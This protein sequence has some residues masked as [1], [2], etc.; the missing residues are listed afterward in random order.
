MKGQCSIVTEKPQKEEAPNDSEAPK[1]IKH[2]NWLLKNWRKSLL[3]IAIAC[4]I[5]VVPFVWVYRM[6]VQEF[7]FPV[8][9]IGEFQISFENQTNEPFR[10]S[11]RA[12]LYVCAPYIPGTN[13]R[14][15]SGLL[16]IADEAPVELDPG[17]TSTFTAVLANETKWI[18]LVDAGDTFV[19][20]LFSASPHPIGQEFVLDRSLFKNGVNMVIKGR[21]DLNLC[22][23]PE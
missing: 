18:P 20:V 10:I 7:L 16:G 6:D 8:E 21:H 4:L 14:V 19:Q 12:E 3:P 9:N 13:K 1:I 15:E 5:A 23:V 22:Y 11:D 2:I 17:L